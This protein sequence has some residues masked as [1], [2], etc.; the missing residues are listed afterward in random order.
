MQWCLDSET[1]RLTLPF[2]GP[3]WESE[4]VL[5]QRIHECKGSFIRVSWLSLVKRAR[6]G[7]LRI[8][9]MERPAARRE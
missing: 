3:F 2:H 6:E 9:A 7:V 1:F 5:S 4:F 8:R